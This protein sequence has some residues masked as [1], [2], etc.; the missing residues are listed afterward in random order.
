MPLL[1]IKSRQTTVKLF[2]SALWCLLVSKKMCR[3][4][5]FIYDTEA[6]K[7]FQDMCQGIEHPYIM[8]IAKL[9]KLSL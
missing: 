4:I 5:Y 7:T 1:P 9:T 3:A 8:S 6:R 2:S